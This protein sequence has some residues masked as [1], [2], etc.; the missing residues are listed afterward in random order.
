[1][2]EWE[3]LGPTSERDPD[4]LPGEFEVRCARKLGTACGVSY[5]LYLNLLVDVPGVVTIC[6]VC[7]EDRGI[8]ASSALRSVLAFSARRWVSKASKRS[9][10][11][12]P[13]M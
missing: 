2:D 5:A 7:A 4:A 1:M 11:Y 6:A 8:F 13:R 9:G 3:S 12:E 10:S